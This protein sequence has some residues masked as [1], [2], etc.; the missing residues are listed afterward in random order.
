MKTKKHFCLM[1]DF[2]MMK[3]KTLTLTKHLLFVCFQPLYDAVCN[4]EPEDEYD[5]HLLYGTG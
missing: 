3:L 1:A 2:K 4:D 5:N